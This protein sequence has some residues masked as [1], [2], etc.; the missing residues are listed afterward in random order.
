MFL[1]KTFI[2][3]AIAFTRQFPLFSAFYIVEMVIVILFTNLEE[4]NEQETII[5]RII[6]YSNATFQYY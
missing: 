1:Q 6:P 2:M 4:N 3:L 5:T